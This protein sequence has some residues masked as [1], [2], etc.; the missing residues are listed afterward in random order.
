M[1]TQFSLS[2]LIKSAE[3]SNQ[4]EDGKYVIV[5]KHV[6]TAWLHWPG[7]FILWLFCMNVLGIMNKER[8]FYKIDETLNVI[9]HLRNWT[10]VMKCELV[11]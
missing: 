3:I 2:Q 7:E 10:M 4:L 5:P 1:N 6:E 9:V 11:G 8:K